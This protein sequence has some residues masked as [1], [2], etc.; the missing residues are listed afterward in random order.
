MTWAGG[1]LAASFI[2]VQ[3]SA[4]GS[5]GDLFVCTVWFVQGRGGEWSGNSQAGGAG[6]GARA[7][8]QEHGRAGSC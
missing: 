1:S 2:F 3:A 7:G 6:E 8:G 4:M 5:P